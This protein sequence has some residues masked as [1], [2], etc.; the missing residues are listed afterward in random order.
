MSRSLGGRFV[1]L[2]IPLKL[3]SLSRFL[4]SVLVMIFMIACG[5]ESDIYPT[6]RVGPSPTI[7]KTAGESQNGISIQKTAS[8]MAS[9]EDSGTPITA[10]IGILEPNPLGFLDSRPDDFYVQTLT[11]PDFSKIDLN[12]LGEGF[13]R[14]V[15]LPGAIPADYPVYVVSPNTAS[16]TLTKAN[17]D[18]SFNA[19]I[20][21]PPGSWV[22]VKYDPTGGDWLHP[23][24]LEDI[25][26]SPVNAAIGAMAQVPFDAPSGNGIPFVVSGT[27]PDHLDFTLRGL[28]QGTLEPGG[29]VA[30]NGDA[31]VYADDS[32]ASFLSGER[33][34]FHAQ[35][36]PFA[37]SAGQPRIMANQFFSTIFTPTGLPIEHW[38]GP[39]LNGGLL[40]TEGLRSIEGSSSLT[41][42]FNFTLEISD[43][44]EDGIYTVWLDAGSNISIGSLGGPRPHV[45]PFMTNHAFALPP[46]GINFTKPSRLMW[47]LLTDVPSATGDRG[48]I[49]MEDAANFQIAN[50]IVTQGRDY[51]IPRVSKDTGQSISYR[52]EPYLPMIAHGDRYIPNVPTVAFK[53]PSGSLTV[54]VTRPGGVVDILGPAPFKTA[55]MRTPASSGGILLDNGGGHLADV[56]QL[57]TAS[58]A[59]DYQFMNYGKHTI[60]MTGTAEDIYGNTYEGGGTYTVFVAEPLDIEP[61]T[62]PMTPF[63]V[64][65]VL[66]P[67]LTLLPG[68]PAQVEVKATLFIES[69]STKKIEQL[70]AGTANRFGVFTPP[71]EA[72]EIGM[73]GPGELLVET[74]AS[75][76]DPDGVLWM[77]ST[78][79][80]QVVAPVDT[81]MLA[82]GRRGRDNT[83]V[84]DVKLWF[85]S[86]H[87]PGD[88]SHIN[89]PFA[90]GDVIW[91]TDDDAS[92]VIITAQDTEGLITDAIR[93]WDSDGNYVARGEHSQPTPTL[94]QRANNGELPLTFATKSTINPALIPEEIVSYGYWYAGIQRPGERVR[95]IISDD[96]VGTAYW[97]FGE[98]YALQP[99]MGNQGDL[100][101]DFKFQFG[102][103]VFRDTTRDLN[104]YGIY[105]SLW[106]QLPDE[107][108]TGS[109]VFPPFRGVNG[110]P[111]GGPIMTIGGEEINAFV[112]PLAVRPGT[113]LESGQTFSFSAHL[114]P[115][116]GGSVEVVVSGPNGI[117]NTF[118]GRANTIGYYYDPDQDF[119][120]ET[121]GLYHV[122]V[123]AT[124]DSPTSA[125][126]M[127]S[128]FPTGTVLGAVQD[129]FYIYVVPRGSLPLKTTHPKWSVLDEVSVDEIRDVAIL[130]GAPKK[131][132]GTVYFTIGMPGHLLDTGFVDLVDGWARVLYEPLVLKKKFPNIDISG[133]ISN[134]PGLADTVWINVLVETSGGE[135]YARQF[136]LQG[137]DLIVPIIDG[138]QR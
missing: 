55:A 67:S 101:N 28:M 126:P 136:T 71:L 9:I 12:W 84:T 62:L 48:T 2:D 19:E 97:R 6:P 64:G 46:F 118:S 102:G 36:T 104:R 105:G 95:E 53:F 88:S 125:G 92:R 11:I 90:T 89:L 137:P 110:G 119:I 85:N 132:S 51:V 128:P 66:N 52:L 45:N 108:P 60:E 47:T 27:T 138:E 59:F 120:I 87:I 15:G 98:M 44:I 24:I 113:I 13:T 65:D 112:V 76:T 134:K 20:V 18:G 40:Q 32:A 99:G 130:V 30:L 25:R 57:S 129:G 10:L 70:V 5:T 26:P 29:S 14:V 43:G 93:T 68:V 1:E 56:F 42:A 38:G 94:D 91:Q 33:L 133:R 73:M 81:T 49:A 117:T 50:R 111:D 103:A 31:M 69:D 79:W 116:L 74:T 109:R 41:A 61:A 21:A 83:P 72:S 4:V 135:F 127:T 121:P 17:V 122:K 22:I 3:K 96:D 16:A 39:P 23:R 80:G 114:A 34:E 37:N 63:E 35:L 86:P 8:D 106:V 124:F 82:H 54:R 7:A 58:E 100:P 77:G 131:E 115:T 78:R 123:T 107:D 75:Y